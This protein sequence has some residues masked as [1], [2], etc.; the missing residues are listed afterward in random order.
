MLVNDT[1]NLIVHY[2]ILSELLL[3]AIDYNTLYLH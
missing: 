2:T 1:F 3:A